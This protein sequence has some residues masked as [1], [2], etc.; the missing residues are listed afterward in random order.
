MKAFIIFTDNYS[1][2]VE[3]AIKVYKS[4]EGFSNWEPILF[5]GV[6]PYSI[7]VFEE[8]YEIRNRLNS[9]VKE[10]SFLNRKVYLSKKACFLNHMRIW[11]QCVEINE[12]VA[13]I[14]HDSFCVNNWNNVSFRDVLI[15]NAR[16]SCNQSIIQKN[17]KKYNHD[18]HIKLYPGL[19]KWKAPLYYRHEKIK[20]FPSMMPGTAAYAITPTGAKK[21]LNHVDKH[22]WEQSD[23]FINTNVVNIQYYNPDFFVFKLPNLKTSHGFDN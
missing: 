4:F 14:E 23:H 8:V 7:S 16:S 20:P 12:P 9:R 5:P 19:N 21:L 17:F 11:E 13:F 2:S 6:N 18:C 22:G 1:Q 10:F 15:L 3:Y